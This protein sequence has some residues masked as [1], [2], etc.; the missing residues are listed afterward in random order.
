MRALCQP[1]VLKSAL[2]ASLVGTALCYPAVFSMPHRIYSMWYMETVL[3]LCGA[4]LWGF[5][6]AWYPLYIHRPALTLKPGLWPFVMA[7]ACGLGVALA[8]H[9]L[10]DPIY[11]S[12]L[13]GDYP[14]SL[15]G[16]LA[17]TLFDLAARQLLL[18]FAPFAW[19]LRLLHRKD[20]AV[21]L[22]VVFGVAMLSFKPEAA[23]LSTNLLL[24]VVLLRTAGTLLSVFFFLRGGIVLVC[25][26]ALLIQSR[27]LMDLAA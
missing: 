16:W 4:F 3:F 5:V 23:Q 27:H 22:T 14:Q 11:R 8:W 2:L 21:V 6:F 1:Q 20:L 25:W 10:L 15:D 19:L 7:T 26:W 12:R 18:I 17:A 13:S 24:G 9:F